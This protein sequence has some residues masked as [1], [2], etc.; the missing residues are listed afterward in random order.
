MYNRQNALHPMRNMVD[1]VAE[2]ITNQEGDM[3]NGVADGSKKVLKRR[4]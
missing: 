1:A 2:R 3:S 4:R